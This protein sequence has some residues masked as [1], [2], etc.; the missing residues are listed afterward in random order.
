[1]ILIGISAYYHDSA[2]ALVRDGVVVAAA[3]EERFSR[4]K[5]DRAFPA[6]AV[7]YCV[8]EAGLA[9]EAVDHVVFYEKPFLKFDRLV[10]TW[11]AFAPRGFA[12][13]RHALPAWFGERLF[14]KGMLERELQQLGGGTL[15]AR[16][17]FSEHHLSHAASAFYPSPFD[18]AAVLT[19]DGVGEWTTTMGSHGRGNTLEP[20]LELRFPHSLGLL[21]SAFTSHLGFEVNS[22]EY[23]MMGLAPLGE[24]RYRQQLLDHVIDL[25]QDGSFR[26]DQRYFNYCT[27]LSMTSRQF[28]ERFG[29][30]RR[31]DESL[32][33]HHADLAASVQ[34][35]TEEAM[36]RMARALAHDTGARNLCLAGGVAL[37][38][39]A[40][41]KILRDGC[42]D[43]VW[44]Q[45]AAGDAGGALGAALHA[46]YALTGAARVAD[47]RNDRMA[48]ACLG[49]AF[50]QAEIET[51]LRDLNAVFEV[52]PDRELI[53]GTARAL[54]DGQ[55]IG[56]MQGRMEF[57]PRALGNRSILAD[58]RGPRMRDLINGKIKQREA[59]RPFAAAVLRSDVAEWFDLATDSPYMLLVANVAAHH[60]RPVEDPRGF[61]RLALPLS[62]IPAVTHADYST[63]IQ[64][65]TAE[66]QP[67]FHALLAE[68]KALT[69]CPVLLNTSFN[70]G[71]EPIV[72]SPPD[73]YRCFMDNHLDELVIG[74]C[75]LRRDYQ[76]GARA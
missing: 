52:L 8:R 37:N 30:P 38:C 56:W 59:F 54:A 11:L 36:L 75:R 72:C 68:F 57:G 23:K 62:D 19:V 67:R 6:E 55:V 32:T 18:E 69:G 47:G 42:F 13:F 50:D 73:A 1:M 45:P 44:I 17:L 40:N 27:G 41:S 64:T 46:Y 60:R 9:F 29:P 16:L 12:A 76:A 63:R 51:C 70:G 61:A 26:L 74:N 35:V 22:G 4:R 10:E 34:A 53:A 7:R 39:V 15:A 5:H 58:P 21:Y 65:I 25:K 48:E 49:P 66:S 2:A 14:L 71:D 43:N 31:P 28:A 20:I 3:Q 33:Q 24:P